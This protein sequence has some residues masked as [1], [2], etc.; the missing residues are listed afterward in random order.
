[1]WR[2]ECETASLVSLKDLAVMT[3]AFNPSSQTNCHRNQAAVCTPLM[4]ALEM[5]MKQEE[6]ALRSVSF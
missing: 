6:T 3:D 5:N 2:S 4:P 1:M